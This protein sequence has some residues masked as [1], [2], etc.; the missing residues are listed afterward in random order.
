M[1]IFC[2]LKH[3]VYKRSLAAQIYPLCLPVAPLHCLLRPRD[4]KLPPMPLQE[5]TSAGPRMAALEGGKQTAWKHRGGGPHRP[6]RAHLPEQFAPTGSPASSPIALGMCFREVEPRGRPSQAA[7]GNS[8]QG[9]STE[10]RKKDT[11]LL[12]ST[13]F[14]SKKL[15]CAPCPANPALFG[16]RPRLLGAFQVNLQPLEKVQPLWAWPCPG[17]LLNKPQPQEVSPPNLGSPPESLPWVSRWFALFQSPFLP[18][19]RPNC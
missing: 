13:Q 10:E 14:G 2:C 4:P 12:T 3:T 7:F 11:T 8:P 16:R 19:R 18:Q 5:A 6:P 15:A 9:R 17:L 1:S